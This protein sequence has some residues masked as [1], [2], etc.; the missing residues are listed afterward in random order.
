LSLGRLPGGGHL[1]GKRANRRD[2]GQVSPV[3]PTYQTKMR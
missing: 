3:T 1:W 2:D